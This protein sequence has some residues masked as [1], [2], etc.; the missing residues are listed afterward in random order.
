VPPIA[1]ATVLLIH[2][3]RDRLTDPAR[4]LA[5]ARLGAEL[6]DRL[7]FVELQAAEHKLLR[8]SG[9]WHDLVRRF[10]VGETGVGPRDPEIEGWF[11]LPAAER[12]RIVR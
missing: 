6:T 4:T 1:G 9:I 12:A 11:R 10:V 2:G 8:R 3:D 7:A 5:M